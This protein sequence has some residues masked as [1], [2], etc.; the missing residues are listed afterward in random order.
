MP[1]RI[2]KVR[3]KNNLMLAPMHG[4]NCVAFRMLCK[5]H[6]AGLV[7]TGMLHSDS[8]VIDKAK[9]DVIKQERP[10]SIQIVGKD[11]SKMADAA[12]ML[13]HRADIIDINFG[14][15]DYKILEQKSGA[16]LMKHPEQ[17]KRIA[18]KVVGA[19]NCPVT[20]K[21]R[22][23]W[24][25]KTINAIEVSKM[26]EDAGVSAI[27][28]HGRTKKQAYT[29][30]ANWEMIRKTKEKVNIPIIGNGDIFTPKDYKNMLEQTGVDFVMIGRGA[31]GNPH[32]FENCTRLIKGEK[33][34]EK[35]PKLTYSLFKEFLRYYTNHSPHFTFS[36][37]RK[38][39]IW[40]AKGLDDGNKIK[41][42]LMKT[43]SLEE[44]K[45]VM[46]EVSSN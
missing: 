44:L 6:G 33:L 41:D 22:I 40:L 16:F 26:L 38:H 15:P 7:G 27:S 8:I 43:T 14:C 10:L 21:I 30:K 23:G 13:E 3:L 2:G 11:P 1:N 32:L 29:G 36:E 46:K 39:A 18:S 5:K 34:I 19:V 35:T 31:M 28:I 25:D 24:N 12:R 17:I 9:M 37:I 42:R 4:V 45:T 20:A